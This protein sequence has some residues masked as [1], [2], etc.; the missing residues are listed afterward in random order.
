MNEITWKRYRDSQYSVSQCGQIRNITSG[1]FKCLSADTYGYLV[2]TLFK[3]GKRKQYKVHRMVA[4]MFVDG[5]DD[6]LQVNHIDGNKKNNNY[7]NL[8]WCSSKQ[9]TMHAIRNGLFNNRIN[10][11][12]V[13]K[14]R[15]SVIRNSKDFGVIA[16][17]KIYNV[18]Y[19][20]ISRV[21]NYKTWINSR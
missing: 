11:T 4:E 7:T 1:K 13:V 6:Q 10:E 17:A 20:T 18:S 9:N 15:G 12:D 5:Y 14:I 3:E 21:L 19:A 16:T 2:T 8:E